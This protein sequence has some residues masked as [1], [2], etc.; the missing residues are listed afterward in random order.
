MIEF[1]M[2]IGEYLIKALFY[3]AIAGLGAF[4]GI[5]MCKSSDAKKEAAAKTEE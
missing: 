4:I 2:C 5:K 3:V 1:L